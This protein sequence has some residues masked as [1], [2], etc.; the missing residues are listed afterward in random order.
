MQK[1]IVMSSAYRQSSRVTNELL[2][3]DPENRLIARGPR[4]RL[5]GQSIR[6]QALAVSGLLKSALADLQ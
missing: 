5:N 4:Y 1:L 6:D 3:R 2:E